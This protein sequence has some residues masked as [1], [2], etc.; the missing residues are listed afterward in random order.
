VACVFE[1]D[2]ARLVNETVYFD[3][4]TVARQLAPTDPAPGGQPFGA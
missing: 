4:A 2:G 3:F 1:F